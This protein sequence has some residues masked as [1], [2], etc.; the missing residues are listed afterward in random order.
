ML[1]RA[2]QLPS[3]TLAAY[4][5]SNNVMMAYVLPAGR[6]SISSSLSAMRHLSDLGRVVGA[7]R[8]ADRP[9]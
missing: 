9:D 4:I 3:T 2:V 6:W 8:A 1:V 7:E 5:E